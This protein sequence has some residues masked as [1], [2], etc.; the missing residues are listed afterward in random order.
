MQFNES[1]ATTVLDG[2]EVREVLATMRCW[3]CP[4][5][6]TLARVFI[7]RIAIGTLICHMREHTSN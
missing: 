4:L 2:Q 1:G 6:C 5:E 3:L 7:S